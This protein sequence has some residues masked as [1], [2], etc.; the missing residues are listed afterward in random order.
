[1]TST[2]LK[3]SALSSACSLHT[4]SA[5]VKSSCDS[6][7]QRGLAEIAED[8]R[9]NQSG[10]A[11]G[12]GEKTLSVHSL[13]SVDTQSQSLTPKERI[14][15]QSRQR[16]RSMKRNSSLSRSMRT[17]RNT[18]KALPPT[19]LEPGLERNKFEP[20]NDEN[21][22]ERG[23]SFDLRSSFQ[24][25]RPSTRDLQSAHGYK[26]KVKLGPRPSIDS[27]NRPLTA[28]STPDHGPRPVSTLPSSVRLPARKPLSMR[29]RSHNS[30]RSSRERLPPTLSLSPPLPV[31]PIHTEPVF[32][33]KPKVVITPIQTMEKKSPSMTPEKRRLMKA[34]QLRQKQM[35]ARTPKNVPEIEPSPAV[36]QQQ[37]EKIQIVTSETCSHDGDDHEVPD[38]NK[39]GDH[40]SEIVQMVFR[41]TSVSNAAAMAESSPISIL[42]PSDGPSTQASSITDEEDVSMLKG[43]ESNMNSEPLQVKI[44]DLPVNHDEPGTSLIAATSH[45]LIPSL[46]QNLP[47]THPA[48][49]DPLELPL[50]PIDDDEVLNLSHRNSSS[51]EESTSTQTLTATQE[52]FPLAAN[53]TY[54]EGYEENTNSTRPSTSDTMELRP[55]DGVARSDRRVSSNDNSEDHFLSDDAFMDELGS[56]TVQEAKPISV[57]KS[58]IT[59]F[60]PKQP[61]EQVWNEAARKIRSVS[62]PV[63]DG[64]KDYSNQLSP[65]LPSPLMPRSISASQ[66]PTLES[67]QASAIMPKKIGVSTGISQRIKALEKLSSRPTSPSSQ[68]HPNATSAGAPPASVSFRKASLRIPQVAPDMPKDSGKNYVQKM[69]PL[70]PSSSPESTQLNGKNNVINVKVTS[71][72][73][74][75]RPE[76]IS[77][78][79]TIIRDPRNLMPSIPVNL[80]E[81]SAIDLYKS[82]L[83]VEH[84]S[85]EIAPQSSPLKPPRSKFSTKRSASSSS[86][87]RKSEH[88]PMTRRS[89]FASRQSTPSRRGSEP[90]LPRSLSDTSSTG[91]TPDGIKEEKKESRKSR[92]FKRMSHISSASRRS[93]VYAFNSP[94]KDQPIVEHHEAKY[95]VPPAFADF[96]DVNIQFPDTLVGTSPP[97]PM[98]H[99]LI[100]VL[101]LEAT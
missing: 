64:T 24:S 80:S 55:Q 2:Q 11:Y 42:E 86:T 97:R 91:M 85:A 74:K 6:L 39:H 58:P 69:S 84:Q 13:D 8:A 44:Q 99:M 18:D 50:P 96:G 34:L 76:S 95:E 72:S 101:A 25:I 22:F 90:D 9:E 19:P 20:S 65:K 14:D 94:V 88:H 54:H 26:P 52:F 73:K 48:F 92:L 100:P 56:A 78:T 3:D 17:L 35:A 33:N 36:E 15:D 31:L 61:N 68:A 29:S 47:S 67:Q 75:P 79:A 4:A 1:M 10:T 5:S 87:E 49:T 57:S 83:T 77:V 21:Q 89:S 12:D 40:E 37:D 81:P 82:P 43:L 53:N 93:I 16:A 62:S 41:D 98:V 32:Q 27:I 51:E 59:P 23:R 70:S 45:D 7:R 30:Q 28:D 63:D 66:S 60:F 71:K 46:P 38:L